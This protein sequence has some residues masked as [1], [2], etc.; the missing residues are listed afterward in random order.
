MSDELVKRS[1]LLSAFRAT[2]AS[3]RLL[4]QAVSGLTVPTAVDLYLK[5]KEFEKVVEAYKELAT[6]K[7]LGYTT[8]AG[9]QVTEKGTI[10]ARVGDFTLRA[11]PWRTTL[12]PKKVEKLLR[13]KG[14]DPATYMNTKI[15]YEAD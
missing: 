4:S 15:T 7:L 9:S 10:E 13:A 11:Q 8:S 5:V 14:K 3:F 2:E 6:E 12:D 1:D